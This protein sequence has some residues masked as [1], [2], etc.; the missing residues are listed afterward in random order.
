[1]LLLVVDD[2]GLE[3]ALQHVTQHAHRE[4][5]LLEDQR[6]R[7]D[8]LRAALEHLVELVQVVDLALEVVLL[9]ALRGGADYQPAGAVVGLV[10]QLAQPVALLVGKAPGDPDAAALGHVD[11]IAAGDRELHRQPRAL[12]LQRVLHDLH[13]DLLAR[14]DQLVDATALPAAAARS[15]LAARQD[16]L[17]DVKEAVSL[18]PDVD[19]R[20]LHAGQDVVDHALVDVADDRA[21]AAALDVELGDLPAVAAGPSGPALG[22]SLVLLLPAAALA[23]AGLSLLHRHA[24]LPAIDGNQYS[25]FQ[26]THLKEQFEPCSVCSWRQA[27]LERRHSAGA[28]SP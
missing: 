10:E 8:V 27:A 6:R 4:V 26:L 19:E 15:L 1:V 21:L 22:R 5:G 28:R 3:L 2:R 7:L 9:G 16:D 18:Q 20:R 13:Q 25:L 11:E 12:R 14:L 17:V 24:G 23:A